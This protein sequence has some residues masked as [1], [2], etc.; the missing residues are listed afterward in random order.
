MSVLDERIGGIEAA[1]AL[2][3]ALVRNLERVVLG[4]ERALEAAATRRARRRPSPH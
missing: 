1:I 2:G 4:S 3:Q